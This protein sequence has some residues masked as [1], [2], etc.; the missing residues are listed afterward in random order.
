MTSFAS[1]LAQGISTLLVRLELQATSTP[2]IY[3]G[4]GMLSLALLLWL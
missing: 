3:I 1:Q 2:D 4:S